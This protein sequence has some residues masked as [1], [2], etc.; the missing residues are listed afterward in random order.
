MHL[1]EGLPLFGTGIVLGLALIAKHA[2]L[3]AK[4][5]ES[6]AFLKK[7]PRNDKLGQV[8]LGFGMLWFWLLVAPQ[9]KGA[10]SFL[11]MDLGEFDKIKN[12]LRIAVPVSIVLVGISVKE[13]LAV[14]ALGLVG[15]MVAAPLF[16][17]AFQ[18]PVES[19]LLIPIYVYGLVIASLYFVG[20][21]Y[22]FRDLVT[23]ASASASRWRNLCFAGL[24]Y[25]VAV[26]ACA[27]LFWKGY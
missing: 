3:L 20:M 26:L 17:A 23:W 1:Y 25:G 4:P 27:L 12:L 5:A 8:L 21:P 10:L 24:A 2:L 7:F 13:F 6:Q 16:G 22:L 18:K 11:S 15:L 9:D 19:R 14:R